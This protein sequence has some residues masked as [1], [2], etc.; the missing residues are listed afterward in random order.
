MVD[1]K[2]PPPPTSVSCHIR[3]CHD[4]SL[5]YNALRPVNGRPRL[6]CY[7]NGALGSPRSAKHAPD[8]ESMHIINLTSP[9][10]SSDL[11]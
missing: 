10:C 5:S 1:I 9:S 8:L 4:K 7:K 3:R 11:S 2:S 6:F